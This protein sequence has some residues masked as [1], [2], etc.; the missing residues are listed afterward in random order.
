MEILRKLA[1]YIEHKTSYVPDIKIYLYGEGGE[2]E[3]GNPCDE[4]ELVIKNENMHIMLQILAVDLTLTITKDNA[5]MLSEVIK[6]KLGLI[7]DQDNLMAD[8]LKQVE[9]SF[10]DIKAIVDTYS[11]DESKD[12]YYKLEKIEREAK[13]LADNFNR[14]FKQFSV[15]T[16][17]IPEI[18]GEITMSITFDKTGTGNLVE[19]LFNVSYGN[20]NRLYLRD[21]IG[22][23]DIYEDDLK[24]K[25][26]I[27][28]VLKAVSRLL[29]GVSTEGYSTLWRAMRGEVFISADTNHPKVKELSSIIR[30]ML[31]AINHTV[32]S[33]YKI[34]LTEL[35]DFTVSV[36][37]INA[38]QITLGEFTD[39]FSI[40]DSEDDIAVK[41][42][43]LLNNQNVTNNW[44]DGLT[45]K[46]S[47]FVYGSRE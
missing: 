18:N 38:L 36:I 14:P 37:Q 42:C 34:T 33:Q 5:Y 35:Y 31:K 46:A 29:K 2:D 12:A 25:D 44:L 28:S 17:K 45:K 30:D 13:K 40:H 47:E 43:D 1:E 16:A 23:T 6:E 20:E 21:S 27:I 4:F 19:I 32:E 15:K 22:P 41:I 39:N 24:N 3:H 9:D 7:G 11:S 8:M 10:D 26:F